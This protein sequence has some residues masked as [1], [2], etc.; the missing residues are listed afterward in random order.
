ML[1]GKQAD[2]LEQS[3]EDEDEYRILDKS[4][5]TNKYTSMNKGAGLNCSSYIAGIVE[6]MLNS[7][8]FYCKVSAH[9]YRE[10]ETESP[11]A[12]TDEVNSTTIYVIK[13]A[14]EITAREKN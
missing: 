9:L 2:G 7:S 10:E 5:I 13:F 4:P 11:A 3:I 12:A 6:G 14:K 8:K 1:F